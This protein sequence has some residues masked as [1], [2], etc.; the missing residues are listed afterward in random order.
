MPSDAGL[1]P[2]FLRWHYPQINSGKNPMKRTSSASRWGAIAAWL[3]LAG[4][5][6]QP[7]IPPPANGDASWWLKEPKG[8]KHYELGIGAVSSGATP[9]QRVAPV[10]PPDQ[11]T[12]CPPPI[13]VE[14][15]LIVDKDG[16]V[17][18]VR[19]ADEVNADTHR[20]PFIVAVRVA[21]LQWDFNPLHVNRWSSDAD[22]NTHVV[23][24][25]NL[26][27]SETYVFRFECHAGKASVTN[28][29]AIT[30]HS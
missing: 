20:R 3:L 27:F 23:D 26:P 24:S 13:E 19:V 2:A 17:S 12:A 30:P 5:V 1:V 22:G 18:E 29:S 21:A 14:A 11:L 16:K 9:F 4:C 15:L 10:Y 6:T 7:R 28:G 25:E 8:T